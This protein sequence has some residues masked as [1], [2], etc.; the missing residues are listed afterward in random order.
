MENNIAFAEKRNEQIIW[1]LD[2]GLKSF[3]V[4][5]QDILMLNLNLFLPLLIS[6]TFKGD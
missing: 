3:P 6:L 2:L 5:L 4:I 1:T